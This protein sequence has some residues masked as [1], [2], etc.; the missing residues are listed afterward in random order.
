MYPRDLGAS[1]PQKRMIRASATTLIARPPP[2]VFQFVAADFFENYQRWSPEVVSVQQLS[3]GPVELGTTG[4][5]IRID[6]GRRTDATFRV[7]AFEPEERI[8]FEGISDPFAISYRLE[9]V[10]DGTRLTFELELSRLAFYMRPFERLIRGGVQDAAERI[11]RNIKDLIE[12]EV[13]KGQRV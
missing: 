10:G 8:T 4:R 2:Q 3:Q 5:Q 7:S 6:H 1:P 9:G 11:V 12:A 13:P